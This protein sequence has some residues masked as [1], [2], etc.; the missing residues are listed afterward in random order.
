MAR[1]KEMTGAKFGRLTVVKFSHTENGTAWWRCICDCGGKKITR[2]YSLRR[3]HVKSCGC[4]IKE[5]EWLKHPK[6]YSGK[7]DAG[8]HFL[9]SQYCRNIKHR[10][11]DMD[12][13][14]DEFKSL[15]EKPCFYCGN[16]PPARSLKRQNLTMIANGIDRVDNN[17]G[18]ILDNCV[19]CCEWC[20]RA[21]GAYDKEYFIEQCRKV[22][23]VAR[24]G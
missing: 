9:Y 2:G 22:A 18:Y 16:N 23:A 21:K 24:R 5:A 19:S 1:I 15:S 3:G 8:W 12:L 20:N 10:G 13:S 11:L 14:F 7:R 6:V 17:L 4:L